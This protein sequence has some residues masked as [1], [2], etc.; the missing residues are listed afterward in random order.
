M[1]HCHSTCKIYASDKEGEKPQKKKGQKTWTLILKQTHIS[2]YMFYC[3]LLIKK[4][5]KEE[6]KELCTQ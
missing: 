4:K 6:T 5:K 1:D 2:L 3:F